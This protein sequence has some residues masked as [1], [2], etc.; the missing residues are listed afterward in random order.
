MLVTKFNTMKHFRVPIPMV[1]LHKTIL[2]TS[3]FLHSW[4]MWVIK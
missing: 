3:W 2:M 1:S 4:T